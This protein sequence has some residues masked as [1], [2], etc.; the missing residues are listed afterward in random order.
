MSVFRLGLRNLFV[1]RAPVACMPAL[2]V[3]ALSVAAFTDK[4]RQIEQ[5]IDSNLKGR[6]VDPT[7]VFKDVLIGRAGAREHSQAVLTSS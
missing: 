2:R 7:P 6:L 5:K 4:A 1:R 3:R